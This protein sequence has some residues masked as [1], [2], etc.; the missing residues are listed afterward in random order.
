MTIAR[1][2]RGTHGEAR[3]DVAGGEQDS[4]LASTGYQFGEVVP[5]CR[6]LLDYAKEV[7]DLEVVG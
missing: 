2:R 1:F 3:D 7:E 6:K 4:I 5:T